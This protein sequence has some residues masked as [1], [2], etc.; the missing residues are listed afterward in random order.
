MIVLVMVIAVQSH[1]LV[2]VLLIVKIKPMA[3]T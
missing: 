3:V 2:M 1:G